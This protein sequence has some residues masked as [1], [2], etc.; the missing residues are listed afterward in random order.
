MT[1]EE[2]LDFVK[3]HGVGSSEKKLREIKNDLIKLHWPFDGFIP[4]WGE[5]IYYLTYKEDPICEN[6][7]KRNFKSFNTGY[8]SNSC[9][10]RKEGK[11]LCLSK[12]NDLRKQTNL[13][14][15]GV[16]HPLKLNACKEKLKETNLKRYGVENVSQSKDIKLKKEITWIKKYGVNH[17]FKNK[18]V[19]KKHKNSL[20]KKYGVDNVWAIPLKNGTIKDSINITMIE[21]YGQDNPQKISKFKKS[22]IV[23]NLEKYGVNNPLSSEI[24]KNKVSQTMLQ[25]YGCKNPSSRHLSKEVQNIIQN[26]D[27][28]KKYV[29][30]KSPMKVISELGIHN[31]HC[32][33]LIKKY[34]CEDIIDWTV[35]SYGQEEIFDY[36]S[37]Y[38]PIKNDRIKIKPLEIDIFFPEYNFG[39]EYNGLYWH[40]SK[41]KEKNY[42]LNKFMSARNKGIYLYQFFE[43]EYLF[44]KE[45]VFR[46]ID[47]IFLPPKNITS[48]NKVD[49]EQVL[50]FINDYS[51]E[52]IEYNSTFYQLLIN[53]EIIGIYIRNEFDQIVT[54]YRIDNLY[55]FIKDYL[56]EEKLIIKMNNRFPFDLNKSEISM[57]KEYIDNIYDAGY[58]FLIR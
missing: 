17:P 4:S 1:I 52:E 58:S 18:E 42:H 30:G 33:K 9:S 37:N 5:F 40:S 34:K 49:F 27:N 13:K 50:D 29:N 41:F 14:K 16:E 39:I 31:T 54:K 56:K 10:L 3:L 36:Y 55:S 11:C 48:I 28:F 44:D 51:F 46:I 45:K 20:I 15:Y 43:D 7:H 19:I 23:T 25:K 21:K 12:S 57:V 35:K 26:E 2:I 24:I 22:T 32:Y 6:G 47:K 53:N 8:V 38:N